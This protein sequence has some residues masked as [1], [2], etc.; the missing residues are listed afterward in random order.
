M[1]LLDKKKR[2]YALRS[3]LGEQEAAS[4][5]RTIHDEGRGEDEEVNDGETVKSWIFGG[6]DGCITAFAIVSAAE[7]AGLHPTTTVVLGFANVVADA[8]AMGLGDWTSEKAEQDFAAAE[9][10]REAWEFKHYPTGE[11]DE[12][13]S[14]LTKRFNVDSNDA[15]TL[16]S[17]LAK[18]DDLF[19]ETMAHYELGLMPPARG[20]LWRKSRTTFFAFLVFGSMPLIAY[21]V[22][23]PL[24]LHQNTMFTVSIL[25]TAATL[26]GLGFFQ[27]K[28]TDNGRSGA[29]PIRGGLTILANGGLASVAAFVLS[30]GANTALTV[31]QSSQ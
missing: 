14:I 30:W 29:Y 27:A 16:V 10:D 13:R 24:N 2:A 9:F 3:A 6:L 17:V 23:I 21:V 19:L 4:L 7:G 22:F 5:S 15:E 28:L 20:A 1:A 25:A 12:M 11:I 26:F 31:F 8:L 18:Y